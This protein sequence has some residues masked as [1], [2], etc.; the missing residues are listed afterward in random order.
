MDATFPHIC[1][2]FIL[3]KSPKMTKIHEMLCI[4]IEIYHY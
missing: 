2:L 4:E 3:S 1:I